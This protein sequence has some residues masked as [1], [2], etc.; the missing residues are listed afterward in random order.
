M[1]NATMLEG[2]NITSRSEVYCYDCKREV[3]ENIFIHLKRYHYKRNN[4]V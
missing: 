4:V 3:T 1:I 2:D